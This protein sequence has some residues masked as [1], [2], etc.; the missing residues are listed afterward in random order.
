MSAAKL[1]DATQRDIIKEEND[2]HNDSQ[3]AR[4]IVIKGRRVQKRVKKLYFEESDETESEEDEHTDH[5]DK[6]KTAQSNETND[7]LTRIFGLRNVFTNNL[8][9]GKNFKS[10][11][12]LKASSKPSECNQHRLLKNSKYELSAR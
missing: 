1:G 9:P 5:L 10:L 3:P 6:R 8:L 7:D 12:R 4:K 2:L 11:E